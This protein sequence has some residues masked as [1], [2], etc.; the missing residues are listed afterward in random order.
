MCLFMS[1]P[2]CMCASRYLCL[3]ISAC[4][5]SLCCNYYHDKT[6]RQYLC[7]RMAELCKVIT[8]SV[9]LAACLI[10]PILCI[11]SLTLHWESGIYTTERTT[12][13]VSSM[14]SLII[15]A[16]LFLYSEWW[17]EHG[18]FVLLSNEFW[19]PSHWISWRFFFSIGSKVW[20]YVV[21]VQAGLLSSYVRGNAVTVRV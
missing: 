12:G 13:I 8:Y 20:G 7:I 14:H 19:S 18:P 5:C 16:S 1:V 6:C 15:T 2:V 17:K 10:C 4:A 9:L 21:V 11:S 3:C